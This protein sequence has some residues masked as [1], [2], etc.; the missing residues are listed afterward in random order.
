MS[1]IYGDFT[2]RNARKRGV[3]PK[4]VRALVDTGVNIL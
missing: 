4:V 3:A 1:L 2:I